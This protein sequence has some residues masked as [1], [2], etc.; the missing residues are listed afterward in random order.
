MSFT[1]IEYDGKCRCIID[2]DTDLERIKSALLGQW[3]LTIGSDPHQVTRTG[4]P[5][6]MDAWMWKPEILIEQW[7][8]TV[9]KLLD[10]YGFCLMNRLGGLEPAEK[11]P[12]GV[13]TTKDRLEFPPT[14]DNPRVT[15]SQWGTDGHWYVTESFSVR[16]TSLVEKFN[17]LGAAREYAET[18]TTPDKITVKEINPNARE[19]CYRRIGD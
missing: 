19:G 1:F 9:D 4:V 8:T 17:T 14:K 3:R 15:I 2:D 11:I 7:S 12:D 16:N 10:E 5:L 13:R 6:H 18:R